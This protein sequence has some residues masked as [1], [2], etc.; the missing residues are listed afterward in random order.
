M[1]ETV[2]SEEDAF[3][4]DD[5]LRIF[6][7]TWLPAA[8]PKAAVA[9]VHGYAE[10]SG[11]Y[12]SVGEALAARGYAVHALDLRGHGRSDGPRAL[13]RS[14]ER[15]LADLRLFLDRVRAGNG[16]RP[17]FLLGHSMGGTIVALAS[18]AGRPPVEGILLS[19]PATA[20]N[21]PRVFERLLDVIARI[22]PRLPLTKLSAG[23]VS[24][25]PEVVRRYEADPLVYHGRIR[26]ALLASMLRAARR[27]D[28][29]IAGM[30]LP[31]LFMHG[32]G[33]ALTSPDGSRDLYER[34]GSADKTLKLYD[35]LYHEILNEP[36]RDAVITD[37]V[38]WLDART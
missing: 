34:A 2:R 23:G 37:I 27:I 19:G 38:E 26:A 17:L 13:V 36:E 10:H 5:G 22:A 12:A 9:V 33:D 15:Y 25:D 16:G 11:R 28:D 7:R 3:T 14:F 1:P 6:T 32:T 31:A 8:A 20:H 29:G 30:T 24:R 18:V 4:S 35:G 21:A